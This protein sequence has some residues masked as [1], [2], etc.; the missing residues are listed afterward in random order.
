MQIKRTVLF[1]SLLAITLMSGCSRQESATNN[2]KMNQSVSASLEESSKEYVTTSEDN[3]NLEDDIIKAEKLGKTSLSE[4]SISEDTILNDAVPNSSVSNNSSDSSKIKS[5]DLK[6]L[7]GYDYNI[8]EDRQNFDAE[9]IDIVVGDNYY[10]TQINDWYMN[11][12]SYDGKT[13]EIEGYY[14]DEFSPYL[15]VGRY[16]PVCPYCQGG[17]VSFEFYTD[18]DISELQ[19]GKDWIKVTG[20]LRKGKDDHGNFCYI[21]AMSIEKMDQVGMETVSN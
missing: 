1:F 12:D 9:D 2:Y 10:A 18:E 17:Y 21:E 8:E 16:G 5:D 19:S 20:I 14:I 6:E 7:K 13:V 3:G 4:N 15:F 11:F